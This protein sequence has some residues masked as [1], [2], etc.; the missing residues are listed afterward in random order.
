MKI[1]ITGG[2]G[3]IGSHLVEKLLQKKNKIFVLDN[4]STGNLKNIKPFF[5]NKNFFFKKGSV[6]NKKDLSPLIKKADQIYHLAAAVGV[7][8]VVDNPLETLITNIDGTKNVLEL[9]LSK[10]IP[11]LITSSSEVYGK[12][13]KLPFNED[14]DR[15]Y[16]SAYNHRWGYGLSKTVDEC[17]AL[18]YWKEKQLP[19]VI[20]RLFNTVGSRQSKEYGMV[21]P[22]F[23]HQAKNNKPMTVFGK[24]SQTRCFAH[25]NDIS[26][27]L[28]KLMNTK[29]AQGEVINLGSTESIKIIDLAKKI[30]KL[31]NSESPIKIIPYQK[32]YAKMFDCQQ[33]IPNIKKASS[34]IGYKTTFTLD[35]I[36]KSMI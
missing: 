27:A 11:V 24:G 9:A 28:I 7:R 18:A 2:A 10:K 36:I 31:T 13:E 34:L 5:K 32:T 25:V 1:L 19:V 29:R 33:R 21:I 17:L 3:F 15:T 30:K 12:N 14:S 35:K 22:T 26:N 6:L 8:Y 4:L 20:V 23:I 16:G